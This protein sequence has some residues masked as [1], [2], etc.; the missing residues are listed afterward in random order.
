LICPKCHAE[1]VA[2]FSQCSD[3]LVPLV[4]A[5]PEPKREPRARHAGVDL[6]PPALTDAVCVYRSSHRGQLIMAQSVLRSAGVPFVVLN[7]AVNT[8]TGF[9]GF[10]PVEIQVS[11]ADAE[12]ALLL[13]ADLSRVGADGPEDVGNPDMQ[14]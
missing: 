7:E 13:L 10:G 12:D 2:G 1:Y 11:A 9:V 3:C 14:S 5:L 8:L 6:H 4:D